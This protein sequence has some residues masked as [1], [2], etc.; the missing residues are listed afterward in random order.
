MNNEIELVEKE[1][2]YTLEISAKA[3]MPQMPKLIKTSYKEIVDYFEKN[4]KSPETAPYI[5][6]T[7]LDWEKINTQNKIVAFIKMFT[8]K[9]QMLIGFPVSNPIDGEGKI[10]AGFI[11]AGKYVKAIHKGDYMKVGNTY[12]K[13][14]TFIN[15]K[16][17]KMGA[18]SIEFYL[19]DPK[20]VKKEDLLTEVLIPIVE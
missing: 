4:N 15:D 16:K 7:Q 6:Y 10:T 9:W 2:L 5:R 17:L 12:K 1:K 19:N 8:Q 13:M 20:E 11:P 14:V 3:T 18:E